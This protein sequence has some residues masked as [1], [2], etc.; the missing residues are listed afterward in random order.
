MKIERT[1]NA[2]RNIWFGTILKLYQLLVPFFM[3]TAMIYLLGIEYLGLNSLFASILQVLN[4]AELGVGT[5]MVYSMYQPISEDDEGKICALMN[6]Y[7][8][9]YRVIGAFIL[10]VGILLCPFIPNLIKNG[11]PEDINIYILYLLNLLATVLTYWLFAYKNSLLQAYQRMDVVSKITLCTTT[12]QY[13]VQFLLLYIFKNYYY[14]IIVTLVMQA[15]TNIVTAIIVNNMFPRYHA[16]GKLTKD[17]VKEI[18]QRI[19][20]LFT[21]KVGT[22]IANSADTLVI[23]VFFGLTSL[24][25]YQNYLYLITSVTGFITVIFSS[26]TAGIGNSIIT[27][28][29]DKNFRDLK[30][31]TFI[32]AWITGVCTC[33]F[34]CLFQPFMKLWV[35]GEFML[36]FQAVVCFCIYFFIIEINHLLNTYKDAAGIWHED[37]LRPLVTALFNL[38]LALV[39][40]RFLGIYGVLLSTV[41][42]RLLVG[43]PWLLYNLF[44]VLFNKNPW[45]YVRCLLKYVVTTFLVC[46]VTYFLIITFPKEGVLWLVMR[47]FVCVGISNLLF[48]IVYSRM[49]EFVETKTMLIKFIRR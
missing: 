45:D 36:R 8:V 43:M 47:G 1:K 29:I 5:A 48:L 49:E 33:C 2:V 41:L 10:L 18:N 34:L 7:K 39:M 35:G 23:S 30:K 42:S 20:D 37:R 21:S 31:F 46:I 16:I 13:V 6:L 3:R 17:Q 24:A 26:C 32:I 25:V 44:T 19:R 38:F 40:I 11:I 14:F 12:F 9:Y 15:I 27:E 4:M 22:V 28:P